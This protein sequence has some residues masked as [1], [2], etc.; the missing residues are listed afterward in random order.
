M[1]TPFSKGCWKDWLI[2]RVENQRSLFFF[3]LL[4]EKWCWPTYNC[5]LVKHKIIN[6]T[7]EKIIANFNIEILFVII[8]IFLKKIIANQKY[9]CSTNILMLFF[10]PWHKFFYIA[11]CFINKSP[12]KRNKS[13]KEGATPDFFAHQQ[14]TIHI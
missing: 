9:F 2:F 13:P 4:L 3:L 1:S 12:K 5:W 11:H 7:G 10:L 6:K 14:L 8:I